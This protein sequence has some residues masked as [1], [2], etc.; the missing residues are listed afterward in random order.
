MEALKRLASHTWQQGMTFCKAQV[1]MY[2]GE[3]NITNETS[4]DFWHKHIGHMIEK[5]M[6]TLVKK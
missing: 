2:N 6:Q 1:K 4:T 3:A 5:V